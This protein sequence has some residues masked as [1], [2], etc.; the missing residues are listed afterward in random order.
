MTENLF[1]ALAQ[2]KIFQ[3]YCTPT[4]LAAF[5]L[6]HFL[7]AIPLTVFE[8]GVGSE[9]QG[10]W[11]VLNVAEKVISILTEGIVPFLGSQSFKSSQVTFPSA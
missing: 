6:P 1:M 5:L 4:G 7:M 3:V 8:A 9:S 2:A 10:T 11:E